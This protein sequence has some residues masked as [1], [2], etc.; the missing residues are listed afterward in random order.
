[1]KRTPFLQ[2]A[3]RLLFKECE[4]QVRPYQAALSAGPIVVEQLYLPVARRPPNLPSFPTFSMW[5]DVD[6]GG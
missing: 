4:V 6:N 5:H 3:L 2:P 1:M